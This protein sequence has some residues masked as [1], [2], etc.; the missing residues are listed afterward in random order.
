[1]SW[2]KFSES[3]TGIKNVDIE[4]QLG[5]DRGICYHFTKEKAVV[6]W[7]CRSHGNKALLHTSVWTN[8][9]HQASQKTNECW[10]DSIREDRVVMGLSLPAADRL[11]KDR[12]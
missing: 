5:I 8:R 6:L 10:I 2:G 3:Q 9:W 12:S 1:V 4:N 11:A 7:S